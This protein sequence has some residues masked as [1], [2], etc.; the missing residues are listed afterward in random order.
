[1]RWPKNFAIT[2][3]MP[4]TFR[5]RGPVKTSSPFGAPPRMK[6]VAQDAGR[7]GAHTGQVNETM[8]ESRE[9][10]GLP[11]QT[12]GNLTATCDGQGNVISLHMGFT[13]DQNG[14]VHVH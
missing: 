7:T 6:T 5:S 1:M 3:N 12:S 8:R 11:E 13:V 2:L 4:S 14:N 9:S 10:G